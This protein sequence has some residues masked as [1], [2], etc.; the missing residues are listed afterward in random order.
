MKSL[1]NKTVVVAGGTGNVGSF[2]VKELLKTGA[3]VAVPSRSSKNLESLKTHLSKDLKEEKLSQLYTFVGDIG[4]EEKAEDVYEE[5][6]SKLGAPDVAISSLGKFIP[7]PSLLNTSVKDLQAVV[8]GYL[9]GHFVVA[10][11]FL[12][13]FK[14]TG[15]AYVFINGPL[16][17]A[18]WEGSGAGLV[19]I[20][21]AGQQML[22][23]ALAQ[24]LKDSK[25]KVVELITHAFIRNKQTQPGSPIP[26]EA[27]GEYVSYLISDKAKNVHGKTIQLRSMDQL[28]EIRD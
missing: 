6:S 20:A 12:N 26:G 22:F 2:L 1:A 5:I 27:V 4:N 9:N 17:L 25:V 28:E 10:R 23:K 15:G 18:P 21:T 16:A 3:T 13:K 11:T 24:E 8:D 7:A 19:S 14:D